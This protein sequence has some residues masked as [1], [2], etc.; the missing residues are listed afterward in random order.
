MKIAMTLTLAKKILKLPE[1]A[2]NGDLRRCYIKAVNKYHPDKQGGCVKKF[3]IVKQAMEYFTN[4]SAL[5]S[6]RLVINKT[7]NQHS[8]EQYKL[9]IRT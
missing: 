7:L 2:S 3:R 8:I 4:E 1:G 9:N 6:S 5:L